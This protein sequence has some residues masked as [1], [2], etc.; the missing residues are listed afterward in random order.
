MSYLAPLF[1]AFVPSVTPL[2]RNNPFLCM[3]P[4]AHSNS[5]LIR[6]CHSGALNVFAVVTI[7]ASFQQRYDDFKM[8]F[9]VRIIA[10][11]FASVY[12]IFQ[13]L[14][15]IGVY[16]ALMT[17]T[18]RTGLLLA[19]I[20]LAFGMELKAPFECMSGDPLAFFSGFCF[21]VVLVV[22]RLI[23]RNQGSRF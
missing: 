4:N 12:L 6:M 11:L 15:A 2:R 19:V 13:L 16:S 23:R 21:F 22:Q 18:G 8:V 7:V 20:T 5:K 1:T 14:H 3:F 9:W 17:L 10:V